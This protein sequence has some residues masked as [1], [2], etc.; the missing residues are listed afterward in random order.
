MV[1]Q[2]KN[3]T[4]MAQVAVEAQVQSLARCSGLKDLTLPQLWCWSQLWL[5]FSLWPG[6]FHMPRAQPKKKKKER[7]RKKKKK[8]SRQIK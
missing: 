7:D 3:L 8:R 2:V 4:A 1:Q 5:R 6:N